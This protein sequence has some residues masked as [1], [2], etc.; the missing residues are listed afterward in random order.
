M[1]IAIGCDHGGI[2]L[3]PVLIDYL[4]LKGY[5][6]KDFGTFSNQSVDYNDYAEAVCESIQKGEADLGILICGTG[7]GMSIVANKHKGI[8]CAHCHDVFSA[9]MTKLHNN[10]NVLAMG[11]RVIGPGLM[12]EIVEAFLTTPFSNDERHVCRVNKIL[13]LEDKVF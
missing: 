10:A 5:E 9:K 8:R 6:F 13:D 11:E 12:I 3:K 2:N 1:K 4:T 7:I